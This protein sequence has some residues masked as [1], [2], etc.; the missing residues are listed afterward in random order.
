MAKPTA[1]VRPSR[2]F[3]MI[4][5]LVAVLVLSFGLLGLAM[6]QV[7][8]MKHNTDAYLRTQATLL[9]YDIIDRMRANVEAANS[10]GYVADEKPST[11]ET[12]GNTGGCANGAALADY[13]LGVWYLK[14]E[15]LLPAP[16]V[17]SEIQSN[18]NVHTI[19]V[20]WAERDIQKSRSWEVEL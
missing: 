16:S 4:E 10:G 7:E 11:I 6:L 19:I 13:D 15:E 3:T 14:L 17:P 5:V 2:G 8:S 9:A 18:N 20:R 12:C 1:L